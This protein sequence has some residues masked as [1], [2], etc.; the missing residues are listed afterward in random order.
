[1][2]SKHG[3][4]EDDQAMWDDA[5]VALETAEMDS[6]LVALLSGDEES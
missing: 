1:M 6:E 2:T 4:N 3:F 5:F